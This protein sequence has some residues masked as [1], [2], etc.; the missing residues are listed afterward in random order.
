MTGRTS[1]EPGLHSGSPP[2]WRVMTAKLDHTKG[3]AGILSVGETPCHKEGVVLT[4]PPK[5]ADDVLRL[6]GLADSHL[7]AYRMTRA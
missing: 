7:P 5:S 4:E 3:R 2:P 1:T 6:A